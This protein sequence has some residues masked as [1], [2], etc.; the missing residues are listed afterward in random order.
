M[1]GG[2]KREGEGEKEPLSGPHQPVSGH[3]ALSILQGILEGVIVPSPHLHWE[4]PENI[5]VFQVSAQ[6]LALSPC[7]VSMK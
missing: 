2:P 1:N 7:S 5:S 3:T 6:G 4:N